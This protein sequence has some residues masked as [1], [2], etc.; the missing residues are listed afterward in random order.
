M[1][2]FVGV[3]S[4]KT[5]DRAWN[6]RLIARV[7]MPFG[8]GMR[9]QVECATWIDA[10]AW[11]RRLDVWV[12]FKNSLRHVLE[13][14]VDL[15]K[16]RRQCFY[17]GSNLLVDIQLMGCKQEQSRKS[18]HHSGTPPHVLSH[19]SR[20]ALRPSVDVLPCGSGYGPSE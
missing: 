19:S 3:V 17:I 11:E 9:P 8:D 14:A 13:V 5:S 18:A 6:A 16:V 12:M 15:R 20:Q 10:V 4:A 1:A 7:D 2:T